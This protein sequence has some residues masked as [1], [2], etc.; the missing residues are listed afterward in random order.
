MSI[1]R[2]N[3]CQGHV[4]N[5]T[6]SYCNLDNA[7]R[8]LANEP[9]LYPTISQIENL[10]TDMKSKIYQIDNDFLSDIINNLDESKIIKSTREM[11]N[12]HG[13]K[14]RTNVKIP[15][16][17][18]TDSNKIIIN[19]YVLIPD[20]KEDRKKLLEFNGKKTICPVD[21]CLC[22][23]NLPFKITVNGM[24]KITKFAVRVRSFKEAAT[25]FF[26]TNYIKIDPVT[27][28]NV[29]NHIGE[30]VLNNE[31]KIANDTFTKLTT[32]KLKL[33]EKKFNHILYI[34][35]DGAMVNTRAN[36]DKDEPEDKNVSSWHENKMALIYSSDN[37][38]I[39]G[40][41]I[42][43]GKSEDRH[44][45]K[46]KAY[47]SYV[48]EVSE[49]KKL[50]FSCA[51]EHGYGEYKQTVLL[52]DGATW[53]RNLKEEL[54][55]DA[56]QILDFYHLSEKIWDLGKLYYNSDDKKYTPFCHMI[57][58]MLRDSRISEVL[59]IIRDMESKIKNKKGNKEIKL[60]Q[61]I[62]KNIKNIDYADYMKKGY[63]IGSGGIESANKSVIQYRLKQP[64]MRWT[65]P[66]ARN[67][68]MLRSISQSE[69]WYTRVIRPVYDHYNINS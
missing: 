45:I 18:L 53:I 54:F 28:L 20:T 27:I 12:I 38:R 58:D 61:Y 36:K 65:I 21:D 1:T 33:P 13:I 50:V 17:L 60:A 43:N 66:S 40:R 8:Q 64:G 32:G 67:M 6:A 44:S 4:D 16:T 62:E 42:K 31:F 30:I 29:T 69:E 47:T 14:L 63:I 46:K 22:L 11:Y 56:Q 26:E 10:Y 2:D 9:Q 23:S 52:S 48:G 19:R 7:I 41:I 37:V 51:L 35:I 3:Y 68:A 39:T 55:P 57:C 5:I 59:K 25:L 34:Q 24:L 15:L 49:F